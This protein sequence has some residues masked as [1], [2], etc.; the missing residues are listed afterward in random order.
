M[1]RP[2]LLLAIIAL[3]LAIGG[4][5]IWSARTGGS[6]T[7][8]EEIKQASGR[9]TEK[10]SGS[11]RPAGPRIR[12]QPLEP[13]APGLEPGSPEDFEAMITQDLEKKQGEA[14]MA[15]IHDRIQFLKSRLGLSDEQAAEIQAILEKEGSIE[16]GIQPASL[17]QTSNLE[18]YQAANEAAAKADER[19]ISLLQPDQQ[20]E[21]TALQ[22]ERHE[23]RAEASLTRDMNRLKQTAKP[24]PDQEERIRE[25]FWKLSWEEE[26]QPPSFGP[27][28]AAIRKKR[29]ARLSILR[30]VLTLE[31]LE[32][33]QG[34]A[35]K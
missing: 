10:R 30:D 2:L 23:Q 29:E 15:T 7:A 32:A 6:Q 22:R 4:L 27:K 33:Y 18:A 12:P 14:R 34:K 1:K 21:Y 35:M 5:G 24:S 26:K 20:E 31:Q 25:A 9:P 19:I 13:H 8:E 17:S 3:G 11:A 28:I 16:A